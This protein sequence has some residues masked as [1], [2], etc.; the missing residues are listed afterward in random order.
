MRDWFLGPRLS[1]KLVSE[2]GDLTLRSAVVKVYYYHLRVSNKKRRIPA[3]GTKVVV[4][5]IAKRTPSGSFVQEPL[6]FPLQLQWTPAEPGEAERT[7]VHES[8]CDF[9]YIGQNDEYFCPAMRLL[10]NNFRGVVRKDECARF[11]VVAT[12]QNIFSLQSVIFE[13]SWDGQWTENQ[14]EMKR[15]LVI[16]EVPSL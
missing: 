2:S 6:V 15:H 14:E 12:G 5:R 11:E 8:T 13:V 3:Q 10:P 4:Q 16:R 9:G 1:L 7:V